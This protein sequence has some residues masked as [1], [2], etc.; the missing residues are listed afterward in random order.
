MH[1]V[2]DKLACRMPQGVETPSAAMSAPQAEISRNIY[3]YP[4]SVFFYIYKSRK[5]R[6]V[7][8][9]EENG[10]KKKKNIERSI[11]LFKYTKY[12]QFLMH[13]QC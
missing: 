5:K 11:F 7:S 9:R 3:A 1:D 6:I 8:P 2:N 13:K 4:I 10:K 12:P